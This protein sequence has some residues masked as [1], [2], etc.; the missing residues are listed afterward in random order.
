LKNIVPLLSILVS[1]PI[2]AHRAVSVCHGRISRAFDGIGARPGTIAPQGVGNRRT[3]LRPWRVLG[4]GS[5]DGVPAPPGT[6]SR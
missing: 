5:I 1:S 2:P 6:P 3:R 4:V